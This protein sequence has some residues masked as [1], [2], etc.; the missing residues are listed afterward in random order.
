M[1]VPPE[2]IETLKLR[3]HLQGTVFDREKNIVVRPD[4]KVG[5]RN[6]KTSALVLLWFL[7]STNG[8]D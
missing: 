5:F 1:L 8:N 3:R 4:K 7:I 6:G 2:L